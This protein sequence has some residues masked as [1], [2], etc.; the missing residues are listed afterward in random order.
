MCLSYFRTMRLAL[1]FLVVTC[2]GGRDGFSEAVT[3]KKANML[4][5]SVMSNLTNNPT[6]NIAN[7]TNEG[8]ASVNES[9]IKIELVRKLLKH[10]EGITD[11]IKQNDTTLIRFTLTARRRTEV[12]GYLPYWMNNNYS[13]LNLSLFSTVAFYGYELDEKTGG[14][15]T[16]NGWDTISVIDDARKANCKISLCVYSKN[17]INLKAFLKNE[18]SQRNLAVIIGGQLEK[19]NANG[20]NIMFDEIDST[21]R[22]AFTK[23]IWSFSRSLKSV[24]KAYE[25]TITVPVLDTKRVYDIQQLDTCTDHFII[26][27]TKKQTYGP[28]APINGSVYSLEA[29]IKRYFAT[30]VPSAKWMACMPYYGAL[31]D[32]QTKEFLKYVK[33]NR[34]VSYYTPD[35]G[36]VVDK[37][38]ARIDVF[39]EQ[40]SLQLWYDDA[41]TL[42]P[43]YNFL[44]QNKLG[45]IGIWA[46]GYDDGRNELSDALISRLFY[47]DTINTARISIKST[48]FWFAVKRELELYDF[49]FEH[50]CQ[51]NKEMRNELRS[52]DYIGYI[53]VSL[54]SILLLVAIFYIFK[55]RALGE[56]WASRKF[57]LGLLVLMVILSMISVIMYCFLSPNFKAFGINDQSK[58]ET[59]FDVILQILGV[60][61]LMGLLAMKF[62]IAPLIKA[63][64]TP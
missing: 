19:R 20:V 22:K 17:A 49:L 62:L 35:Y 34:V 13:D 30:G 43:K 39:D 41:N 15:K 44:L 52:D 3:L 26:D 42:S 59:S 4:V 38:E 21:C 11:S 12:L 58:C 18:K 32:F 14:Y 8:K 25:I 6:V 31:W 50:P 57:F 56:D 33:Y 5:K 16:L 63:K 51:F 45:G 2:F 46:M 54:I 60:G 29:G 37:N 47:V 9:K 10:P 40:D 28:I 7:Q 53:S 48:T 55:L 24:N 27:F 1:F 23:F 64:E 36:T 61:F